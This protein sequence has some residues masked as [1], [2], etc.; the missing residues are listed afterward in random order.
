MKFFLDTYALIELS[1]GNG[2]FSKY[3]ESECVTLK[4]N[5][6]ELYYYL[7]RKYSEESAEQSLAFFL[8]IAGD[9]NE[10]II[11]S[12]MKLRLAERSQG[13]KF[14]YIDVLGYLYAR[15]NNFIFLTGDR[16]FSKLPGVSIER[17]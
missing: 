6:A 8:P 10:S 17:G 1:E 14:S 11:P 5:M 13:K 9:F 12:A 4:N 3:L 7:L 15:K 2:S 16:A